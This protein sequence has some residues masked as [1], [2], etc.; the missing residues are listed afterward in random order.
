MS[1]DQEPLWIMLAVACAIGVISAFRTEARQSDATWRQRWRS[2]R[3][4]F[5]GSSID[6]LITG[7][8]LGMLAVL[9]ILLLA[10]ALVRLGV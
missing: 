2:S 8:A 7:V 4:S 3:R 9:A 6:A 5:I 1:V 10:G